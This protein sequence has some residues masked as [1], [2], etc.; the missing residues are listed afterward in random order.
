MKLTHALLILAAAAAPVAAQT[1]VADT[2]GLWSETRTYIVQSA[3]DV[4]ESM[5]SFKPT[6]DVRTFGELI[7][8][9]AGSQSMFCLIALG[10]KPPAED[11]VEKG[12]KTKAALLAALEAS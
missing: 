8:H 5:Y 1:P 11:A 3:K 9:I 10:E 6:P 4:P 2:R 12:P 7:A